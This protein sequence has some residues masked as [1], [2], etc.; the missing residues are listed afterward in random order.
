MTV[1][2]QS[3]AEATI[4]PQRRSRLNYV[5]YLFILPHL[6]FFVMFLAYPFFYGL[7]I[8]LFNFDFAFPNYRPFVGLENYANLFRPNSPQYEPFW[9]GIRNTLVFVLV[10]VPPMILIP[11]GLAVLLNGKYPGRNFFR[12]LFFAPWSLSVVV[13]ATLWWWIFQDVGGL[14]NTLL[15]RIGLS[16]VSWLTSGAPIANWIAITICTIWWTVGFNTAILLAALQDI[17]DSLYEAA[18]I[19]GAT[20]WQQ[21]YRITVPMLRPVLSFV[22][23]IQII[24]SFNLYGQPL[25]MT[26][27]SNLNTQTIIM[28]ITREGINNYRMG[29]AA[30]MSII[31]AV[32]MIVTTFVATRVF[33]RRT[34]Y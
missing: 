30:S 32:M 25:I 18:A 33:G 27:I 26:T 24:A 3:K 20:P 8:S 5:P 23:T 29:S 11:L 15:L 9:R 2:T 28:E 10:S 21:F 7:Y 19:D 17:P 16:P 13:A 31:V 34:D 14:V 6:I 22:L 4:A 1:V 12:A